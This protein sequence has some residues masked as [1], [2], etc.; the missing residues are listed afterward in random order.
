LGITR[1]MVEGGARIITSFLRERLV[2]LLVL[3]VSP[4]LVGGLH[5]VGDLGETDPACFPRLKKP[6]YAWRGADLILWGELA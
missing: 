3:T 1:L 6:G 4:M 2:D 5:A